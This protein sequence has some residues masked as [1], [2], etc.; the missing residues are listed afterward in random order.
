MFVVA[1]NE[2]HFPADPELCEVDMSPWVI[3]KFEVSSVWSDLNEFLL[4]FLD[5][6]WSLFLF[7]YSS[8][9]KVNSTTFY[10]GVEDGD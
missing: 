3:H 10:P 2:H 9:H 5:G 4:S 7:S 8:Y 6:S 1:C